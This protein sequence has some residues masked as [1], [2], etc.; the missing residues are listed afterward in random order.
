MSFKVGIAGIQKAQRAN[1]RALAALKPSG[2][3]GR[4]VQE[5]TAM[6]QRFAIAITHVDTGAL[7]ASH[8]MRIES[9]GSRG[10]VFID[11]AARNPRSGRRTADY[12]P[13]EHRRGG[14]HAFYERT[15]RE[16]GATIGKRGL[17]VLRRGLP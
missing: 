13:V 3:M 6:A 8:R 9:R 2:A 12:G 15:R 14:T 16:H 1:S 17:A 7:R 4:A 5:M 10:R 11:R